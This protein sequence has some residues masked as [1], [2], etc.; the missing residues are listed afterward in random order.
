MPTLAT[1]IP[2]QQAPEGFAPIQFETQKFIANDPN[3][4]MYHQNV[5]IPREQQ[6]DMNAKPTIGQDG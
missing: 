1:E 4:N 2:V 6:W 3:A 5:L